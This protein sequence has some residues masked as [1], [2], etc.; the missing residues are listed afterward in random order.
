[1]SN[2]SHSDMIKMLPLTQGLNYHS[3]FDMLNA[4][5]FVVCYV[6]AS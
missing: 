2:F 3:F 6:S 1:M 5:D 4:A